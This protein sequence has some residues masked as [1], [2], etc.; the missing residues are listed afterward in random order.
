MKKY[1]KSIFLMVATGTLMISCDSDDNDPQVPTSDEN[2]VEVAV[3]SQDLTTLV[4]A[5][6]RADLVGALE[7]DGNFTVLA[8]SNAAFEAFLAANDDFDSLEDIPVEILQQVLLNHVI[9]G[10]NA[11]LSSSDL[12]V[13]GSGYASTLADGPSAGSKITTYFNTSSG[14]RFNGVSSVTT[15]DIGASNGI[16]H[17]VDAVIPLPT[18][19]TFATADPNFSTLVSALTELT[20]ET[21]FVSLL[22]TPNGETSTPF[23]VFAPVDTAF[24]KLDAIPEEEL[25]TSILAHHVITGSNVR[26]EDINDGDI[27]SATFEGDNLT[28]SVTGNGAISITDGSGQTDINVILGNVQAANGVIHA[29]DTVMIPNTEEEVEEED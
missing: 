26:A 14:V 10:S 17:I 24:D 23:T 19:V 22:S 18:V 13:A 4:A 7:A 8:P 27:S 5:L 16:V 6:Q 3:G 28:F 11:A 1:L 21:D 9:P 15:A 20:P 25:L 29:L 2:I 12:A